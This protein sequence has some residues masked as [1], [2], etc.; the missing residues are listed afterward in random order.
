MCQPLFVPSGQIQR[1][2]KRT[3]VRRGASEQPALPCVGDK[4]SPKP[5]RN[6]RLTDASARWLQ[7]QHTL[8]LSYVV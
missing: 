4:V 7:R 5:P 1:L 8:W 6:Q 3:V 2:Q